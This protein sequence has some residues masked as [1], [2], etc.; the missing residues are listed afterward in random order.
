VVRQFFGNYIMPMRFLSYTKA[1]LDQIHYIKDRFKMHLKKKNEIRENFIKM[2]ECETVYLIEF[3]QNNEPTKAS[4]LSKIPSNFR[5]KIINLIMEKELT[6]FISLR[7]VELRLANQIK[8]KPS[9]GSLT[10][11]KRSQSIQTCNLTTHR[12]QFIVNTQDVIPFNL[13][14]SNS[15]EG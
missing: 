8:Q 11:T 7:M 12:D 14:S 9:P 13:K 6:D 3:F 4:I 1:F 15:K 2:W 5:N 10:H